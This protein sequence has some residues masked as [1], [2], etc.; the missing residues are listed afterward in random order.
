MSI[1]VAFKCGTKITNVVTWQR[2]PALA[3]FVNGVDKYQ[4]ETYSTSERIT[5]SEA[6]VCADR[7]FESDP[8]LSF[9]FCGVAHFQSAVDSENEEIEIETE[10]ESGTNGKLFKALGNMDFAP[11][12]FIA[13]V[14]KPYVAGIDKQ[15]SVEPTYD[16]EAVFEVQDKTDVAGAIEIA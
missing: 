14:F 13:G 8:S 15:G 1:S 5:D 12:K 7:F 9:W 4:A 10:P 11:G 16:G 3:F 6:Q 2:R